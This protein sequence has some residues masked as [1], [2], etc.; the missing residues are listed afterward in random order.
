MPVAPA[1]TKSSCRIALEVRPEVAEWL[2]RIAPIFGPRENDAMDQTVWDGFDLKRE[3]Q[4]YEGLLIQQAM[5]ETNL[6]VSF[7]ARLLG[8]KHQ[9]LSIILR[10]RQKNLLS[11]WLRKFRRRSIISDPQEP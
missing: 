6:R 10:S 7:A 9:T 4:Q 11:N 2:A 1:E 3:I 5:E 8:I